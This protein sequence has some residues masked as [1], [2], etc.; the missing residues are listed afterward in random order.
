MPTKTK[1][2]A[3][4]IEI[5]K[6]AIQLFKRDGYDNVSINA[7][8]QQV[9]ISK[10]TFYYYFKSKEEIITDYLPSQDIA[11]TDELPNILSLDTALEQYWALL[12]INLKMN[13][14]IGRDLLGNV[15]ISYL[16]N[17]SYYEPHFGKTYSISSKLLEKA[18]REGSVLNKEPV[19]LLNEAVCYTVRGVCMS[20][21]MNDVEFDL[22]EKCKSAVKRILII[23]PGH[24]I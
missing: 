15:Y 18:Q 11:I 7:I 2:E 8:C 13:A 12:S 20:W 19:E 10:T 1:N 6:I 23:A 24:E 4:K 9:G 22:L 21:A 3:S 14:E 5:S 16:K 17:H